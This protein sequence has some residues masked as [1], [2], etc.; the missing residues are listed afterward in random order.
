MKILVAIAIALAA[1]LA[2]GWGIGVALHRPAERV[3]ASGCAF[4]LAGSD[5]L[6]ER[7]APALAATFLAGEGYAFG[8][9]E[10]VRAGE[11]RFVGVRGERQCV[12]EIRSHGAAFGFQELLRNRAEIAM[13][14]RLIG[15]AEIA[16]L[17]A[18]G[19]GD[20]AADPQAEH[21]I[22]LDAIAVITHAGNPLQAISLDELRRVFRGEITDWST[23]GGE[24]GP[25]ELY[26]RDEESGA[27]Q[28]FADRVLGSDAMASARRLESS[29]QLVSEVAANPAAI[30][31]VS[32]ANLT[33]SVRTLALSM[34]GPA[35]APNAANIRAEAYPLSRRLYFYVRPST[36]AE[37]GPARRF[38]AHVMSEAAYG[39]IER[40]GFVSLRPSELGVAE[41]AAPQ[42]SCVA[43]AADAE[44]YRRLT[45][46][47]ERLASVIRFDPVSDGPDSLAR[48]DMARA[49]GVIRAAQREGRVVSLIGH[50][51]S[52]GDSGRA[53]LL[54]LQRAAAVREAL[55]SE[56][57]AGLELGSAGAMCPIASN[58]TPEGRH[59]NRRV[60]IWIGPP[61]RG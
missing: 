60:E 30:G 17:R 48:D 8:V 27:A 16:A 24:A 61:Q 2:V 18:V 51:D 32:T 50:S 15:A 21:I 42:A 47:A 1:C 4:A 28:F 6:G 56:G 41:T 37:P 34:D 46:G 29:A 35:F 3:E 40:E 5:S 14:P 31:F 45:E 26:A 58:Q 25:I 44:I 33:P 13:S 52:V 23:L 20:F 10:H 9:P 54:A 36:L 7:L 39:V 53:R 49:A 55:E 38:M 11:A 19:A 22:A 12:I 57:V 59:S 43:G